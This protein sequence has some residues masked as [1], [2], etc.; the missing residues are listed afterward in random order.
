MCG[1]Y[2]ILSSLSL[3]TSANAVTTLAVYGNTGI[4][5]IVFHH[6]ERY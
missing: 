4:W 2:E 6:Y 5:D 3:E 1:G